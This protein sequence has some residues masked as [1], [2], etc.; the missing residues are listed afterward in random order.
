MEETQQFVSAMD[1]KF[2]LKVD[3]SDMAEMMS[4]KIDTE[5]F[6]KVFPKDK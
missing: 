5:Q 3:K 2:L 6:N 4:Q 1:V